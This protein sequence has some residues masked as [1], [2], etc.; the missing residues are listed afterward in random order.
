MIEYTHK[1]K[2]QFFKKSTALVVAGALLCSIILPPYAF[3]YQR[4]YLSFVE[5]KS[6]ENHNMR[7]RSNLIG[8]SREAR[9]ILLKDSIP[10]GGA[11]VISDA[12]KELFVAPYREFLDTF[13]P[14]QFFK[15]H[16]E[17]TLG[18]AIGILLIWG[19]MV[20]AM[21]GAPFGIDF[22]LSGSPTN[23]LGFTLLSSFIGSL[24]IV[25]G[26]RLNHL[27]E[28]ED[29]LNQLKQT[30]SQLSGLK[31]QRSALNVVVQEVIH[32]NKVIQTSYKPNRT[33]KIILS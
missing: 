1:Q 20:A 12:M 4:G 29:Q 5:E 24:S 9:R 19:A 33:E 15:S 28:N 32:I 22:L 2:N 7:E 16:R 3:T 13:N 10:H 8:N 26:I 31:Q 25:A 23:H 14:V 11:E 6:A 30:S 21:I 18:Q 17:Q 27:K